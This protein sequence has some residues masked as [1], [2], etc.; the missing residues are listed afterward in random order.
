[1][2]CLLLKDKVQKIIVI[3]KPVNECLDEHGFTIIGITDFLLRFI[4]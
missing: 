2:S 4:K 1:M 3:D